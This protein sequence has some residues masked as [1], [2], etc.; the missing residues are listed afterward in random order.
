MAQQMYFSST[1]VFVFSREP[2]RDF[3]ARTQTKT[4]DAEASG[5]SSWSLL[6]LWARA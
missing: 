1:V 6:P 2:T 5:V 3:F 4:P